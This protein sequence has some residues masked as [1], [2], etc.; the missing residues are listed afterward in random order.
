MRLVRGPRLQDGLTCSDL[1]VRAGDML[2]VRAIGFGVGVGATVVV[3]AEHVD[4]GVQVCATRRFKHGR[5]AHS[6]QTSG[7]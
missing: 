1:H 6:Q 3:R 2:A 7:Q 4:R 5:Q